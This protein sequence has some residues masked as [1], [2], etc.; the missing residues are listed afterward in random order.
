MGTKTSFAGGKS[1]GEADHSPLSNAEVKKAW[2]F[3][4]TPP[5]VCLHVVLKHKDS[6]PFVGF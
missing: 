6:F 5:Y 3:T 4:S 2:S 1:G